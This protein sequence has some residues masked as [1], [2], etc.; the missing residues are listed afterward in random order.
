[1][2]RKVQLLS[3]PRAEKQGWHASCRT[4]M[5]L[6]CFTRPCCTAAVGPRLQAGAGGFPLDCCSPRLKVYQAGARDVPLIVSLV[7]E[8]ILAVACCAAGRPLLDDAVVVDA[9]LAAQLAP[10]L[11]AHLMGRVVGGIQGG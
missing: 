6:D 2:P 4:M 1:M 9:M 11:S 8:H 7:K 5:L 3:R 10:E